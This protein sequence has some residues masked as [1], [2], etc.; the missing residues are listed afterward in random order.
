MGLGL[1]LGLGCPWRAA[2]PS[3]LSPRAL[4]M[5]TKPAVVVLTNPALL[6]LTK[7]TGRG[8]PTALSTAAAHAALP[9]CAANI[10]AVKPPG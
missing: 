8:A 3:A 10:S 9:N 7:P 1:G 4:L 5:L 6:I 2:M